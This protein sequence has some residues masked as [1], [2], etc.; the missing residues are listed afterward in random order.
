MA[1]EVGAAQQLLSQTQSG[2]L[3]SGQ[4][5]RLEEFTYVALTGR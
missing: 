2:Q 1:A 3:K 5:G 4:T